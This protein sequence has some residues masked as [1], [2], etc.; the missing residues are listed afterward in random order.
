MTW[1]S[2]LEPSYQKHWFSNFGPVH[3]LFQAEVKRRFCP[4]GREVVLASSCTIGLAASLVALEVEGR[5][6]IPSFTFPATAQAVRM[7]GCQPVFIDADIRTWH[8]SAEHLCRELASGA[9]SAVIAVRVFGFCLDLSHIEEI[10]ARHSVPLIIDSAASLPGEIRPSQAVGGQGDIEVFSLHA[11]KVFAIGEGGAMLSKPSLSAPLRAALNFG[12][13]GGELGPRGF[14][15]KL[16]EVSAAIGLKVADGIHEEVERRRAVVGWYRDLFDG[17]PVQQAGEWVGSPP[18][19]TYPVL[20]PSAE[21]ANRIADEADASGIDLRRYYS[22][23]LHRAYSPSG[24][25]PPALPVADTLAHRMVCFP[26]LGDMTCEE[27]QRLERLC[28]RLR[29]FCRDA[30]SPVCEPVV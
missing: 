13:R 9:I 7:A 27:R 17:I 4:D 1:T 14:N 26:V 2:N 20:M 22:P 12:M 24:I 6:A 15:G 16:P 3:N 8:L 21:T 29:G 18:W 25:E 5:V 23:A 28:L 30:G 19:Q 11:T 10:C